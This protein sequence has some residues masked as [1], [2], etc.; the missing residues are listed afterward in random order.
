M[1]EHLDLIALIIP[2]GIFFGCSI[3]PYGI[4]IS[5]NE[6][7]SALHT[8]IL[9]YLKNHGNARVVDIEQR[10]YNLRAVDIERSEYVYMEPEKKISDYF[11]KSPRE[12]PIHILVESKI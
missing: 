10:E 6:P 9:S 5:K 11:T 3:M 1:D 4:Y 7:V 12:V 8:K 2:T